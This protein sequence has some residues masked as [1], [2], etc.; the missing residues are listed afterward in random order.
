MDEKHP[1]PVDPRPIRRKD[2]E[3]PYTIF[4]VGIETDA[5]QYYI[6]FIDNAGTEHCWEISKERY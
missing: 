2:K 6:Q 4:T 3:N 1:F 5:P